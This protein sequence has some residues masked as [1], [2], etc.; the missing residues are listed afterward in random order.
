MC[1]HFLRLAHRGYIPQDLGNLHHHHLHHPAA[2][3]GG[4]GHSQYGHWFW[5]ILST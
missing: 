3:P 2:V 5:V 4:M 1:N